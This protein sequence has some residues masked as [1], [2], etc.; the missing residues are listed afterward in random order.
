MRSYA[1]SRLNFGARL[2]LVFVLF[3]AFILGGNAL[4]FW[5]FRT[6]RLQTDRLA[7]VSRQMM[8]ILR[9]RNSLVSFHKD[10]DELVASRNAHALLLR[11]ERLQKDLLEQLQQ[12]RE[13]L[14]LASSAQSPNTRFLVI[15]DAIEIGFPHQLEAI[16]SLATMGDWDAVNHRV[17]EQLEPT[18][19]EVTALARDIDEAYTAELSRTEQ[20]ARSLQNRIMVLIPFMALSTF[21]IAALCVW[22]IARRV[23]Q[24]QLEERLNERMRIT[25]DLHDTFLQTIQGSR[26]FAQTTLAKCSDVEGMR[27]AI[28][29][30]AR[31]LDRAS[32]EARS[33]LN[34]L[35]A[36]EG[37][38]NNF[39]DALQAIT[40]DAR[41]QGPMDVVFSMSGKPIDV[42]PEVQ[43]EVLRIA[44]EAIT[45][46]RK[47][48]RGSQAEVTL[49]YAGSLS[50]T[51]SDDG[52]GFDRMDGL[53]ALNGHYGL[54]AMH[55]RA[56]HIGGKLTI[57]SATTS[58]TQVKLVVPMRSLLQSPSSSAQGFIRTRS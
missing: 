35:R 53:A 52:K 19:I 32:E 39:A 9:L 26:L 58:G 14:S 13:A 25:R 45:N 6:A 31:W 30:L 43:D 1:T 49:E 42:V 16:T 51:I 3:V 38:R 50:L 48:S 33:A 46:A 40:V 27:D 12:T 56:E 41:A 57:T 36:P 2:A 23:I 11:S 21:S 34:S 8:A 28:A 17:A 24:L 37:D 18:E 55:E 7:V 15:L 44:R 54:R 4:L 5:Q 10:L 29:Q 20:T 22:V 47:H